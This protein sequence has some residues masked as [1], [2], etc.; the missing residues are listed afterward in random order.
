MLG[1]LYEI[2]PGNAWGDSYCALSG[3]TWLE[4]CIIFFLKK[5]KQ[6]N[7]AGREIGLVPFYKL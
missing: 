6:K 3:L 7:T 4:M 2:G 5:K 1:Q